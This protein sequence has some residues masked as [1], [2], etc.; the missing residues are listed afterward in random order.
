VA[1]NTF[2]PNYNQR[3]TGDQK[4]VQNGFAYEVYG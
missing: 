2:G 3:I 1:S 4:K